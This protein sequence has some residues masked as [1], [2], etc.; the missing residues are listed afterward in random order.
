MS[1]NPLVKQLNETLQGAPPVMIRH[2][3]ADADQQ[4]E[5]VALLTNLLW[6]TDFEVPAHHIELHD[7]E[8]KAVAEVD[9]I[10]RI[11]PSTHP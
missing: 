6:H 4:L 8:G 2:G 1:N 10:A 11:L 7:F 9:A 5:S 3:F